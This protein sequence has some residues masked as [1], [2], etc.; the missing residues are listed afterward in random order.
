MTNKKSN[1]PKNTKP[2]F[3]AYQVRN[4]E[5]QAEGYWTKI[6][7]VFSHQDGKGFNVVL[8]AI[9]LDGQITLRVPAEKTE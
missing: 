5:G 1:Q 7:V 8:D 9:P 4:R 3:Y 2:A 6:G